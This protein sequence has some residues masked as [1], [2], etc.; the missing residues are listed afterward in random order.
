LAPKTFGAKFAA[1]LKR[2]QKAAG[3]AWKSNDALQ[4]SEGGRGEED[5]RD[6]LLKMQQHEDQQDERRMML[7]QCDELEQVR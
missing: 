7:E 3:H 5:T 1:R 4:C 2:R 6:G